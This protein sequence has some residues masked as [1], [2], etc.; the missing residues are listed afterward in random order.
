[1]YSQTIIPTKI[2]ILGIE[3]IGNEEN[4]SIFPSDHYCL[5]AVFEKKRKI[6]R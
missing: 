4:L 2:D 1:L 5:T 6:K 3:S